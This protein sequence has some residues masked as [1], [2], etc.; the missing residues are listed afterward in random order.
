MIN[1]GWAIVKL[2]LGLLFHELCQI[3]LSLIDKNHADHSKFE[4]AQCPMW[5]DV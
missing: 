1:V 3:H 5:Y 4:D 2:G